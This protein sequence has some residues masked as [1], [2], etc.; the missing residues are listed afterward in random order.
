MIMLNAV[1]KIVSIKE[2]ANQKENLLEKIN[3]FRLLF[4]KKTKRHTISII[5]Y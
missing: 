4:H 5:R 3:N 2:F 1:I